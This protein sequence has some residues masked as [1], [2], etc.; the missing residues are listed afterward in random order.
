M[1]GGG[2]VKRRVWWAWKTVEILDG[3]LIIGIGSGSSLAGSGGVTG[4]W[5][6]CHAEGVPSG[7]RVI[8]RV[9]H[10]EGVPGGGRVMRTCQVEGVSCGRVRWRACHAD[11]SGGGRVMRTCQVEGVSCGGHAR[12]RACHADVS[13]GGRVIRRA[14]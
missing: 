4:G 2:R 13:G 5:R 6:A 11:V 14:C 12:W 3:G 10:T 1:S 8:R 9:C 7:G